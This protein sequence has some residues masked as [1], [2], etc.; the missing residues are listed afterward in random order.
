MYTRKMRPGFTLVELLVVI[1]ILAIPA[2]FLL[3]VFAQVRL[4]GYKAT[5]ISNARQI[6]LACLMYAQ[7]SDE[8]NVPERLWLPEAGKNISFRA[9][10]QPYV[11]NK[12]VFVCP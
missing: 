2:A 12:W 6:A 7:D 3:P 8:V 10:L 5:C 11:K 1:A 4:D 9:L